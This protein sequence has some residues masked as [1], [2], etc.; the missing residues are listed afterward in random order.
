MPLVVFIRH[1]R[2]YEDRVRQ[3]RGL[4]AAHAKAAGLVAASGWLKNR[5]APG[6]AL[7]ELLGPRAASDAEPRQ[8][9]GSGHAR[10]VYKEMMAERERGAA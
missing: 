4:L 1:L 5:H 6:S 8:V 9:H 10:S 2:G 7:R 3:Q